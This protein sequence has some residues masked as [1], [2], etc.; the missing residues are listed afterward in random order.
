MKM[1]WHDK[2]HRLIAEMSAAS[3]RQANP[4]GRKKHRPYSVPPIA[5]ALVDA[6]GRNDEERAKALFL[7]H[8]RIPELGAP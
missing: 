6:L 4:G 3:Y 5:A 7:V 1:S 8:D 2:A